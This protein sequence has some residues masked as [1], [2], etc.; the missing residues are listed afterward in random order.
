LANF[1]GFIRNKPL[2]DLHKPLYGWLRSL[3][4]A[5]LHGGAKQSETLTMIINDSPCS[6]G[7]L[8]RRMHNVKSPRFAT[9]CTGKAGLKAHA[10]GRLKRSG[11]IALEAA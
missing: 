4:L 9:K 11:H 6:A 8:A 10:A 3:K 2:H 1:A 7:P 5:T